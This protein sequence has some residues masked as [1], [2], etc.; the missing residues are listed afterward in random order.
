MTSTQTT[1]IVVTA[2][3]TK[4]VSKQTF[5]ILAVAAF[6]YIAAQLVHSEVALA[7]IVPAGGVVA[8]W[9][10]GV[11]ERLHNWR[12]LKHLANAVPDEMAVV[13]HVK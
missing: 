11:V 7:A 4:V 10:Y 12:V 13:G 8:L 6:S 1:P 2:S 5:T 3:G 9:A